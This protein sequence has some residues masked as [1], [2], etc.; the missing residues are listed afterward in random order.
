MCNS[1]RHSRHVRH[2]LRRWGAG[3]EIDVAGFSWSERTSSDA[4]VNWDSYF[5]VGGDDLKLRLEA[6][7]EALGTN[8]ESSEVREKLQQTR[9]GLTWNRRAF[10][11]S[12]LPAT[13]ERYS[14]EDCSTS[15]ARY[16]S[17]IDGLDRIVGVGERRTLC[18]Q[19][20]RDPL[21]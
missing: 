21:R 13:N 17:R 14:Y 1:A 20:G 18:R 15:V 7:G 16:R 3:A 4:L 10:R 6:E 11:A 9:S 8:V 12:V 5:W 19:T 2:P